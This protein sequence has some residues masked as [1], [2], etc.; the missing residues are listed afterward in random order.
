MTRYSVTTWF[1][2][3]AIAVSTPLI[4]TLVIAAFT[5]DFNYGIT[6]YIFILFWVAGPLALGYLIPPLMT[7]GPEHARWTWLFPVISVLAFL[8]M[9]AYAGSLERNL[10]ELFLPL[11]EPNGEGPIGWVLITLPA[12]SSMLYSIG[13][14]LHIRS[15]DRRLSGGVSGAMA[16]GRG[17]PR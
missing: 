3:Q 13:A 5:W 6:Q 11:S 1:I 14:V 16:E 10:Q 15:R 8:A 7:Q 4:G 9:A 12:L 2:Q 17:H